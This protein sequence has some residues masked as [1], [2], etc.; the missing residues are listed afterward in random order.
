[1]VRDIHNL[2]GV[3]KRDTE[4]QISKLPSEDREGV[5]QFIYELSAQGYS[6]GRVVKYLYSLVG[7]RKKLDEA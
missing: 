1:M 7:I 3:L 2:K 4:R 6:A 5:K